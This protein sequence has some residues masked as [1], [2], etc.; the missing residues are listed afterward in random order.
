[1]I[2]FYNYF[3]FSYTAVHCIIST[4]SD[5]LPGLTPT[6][7]TDDDQPSSAGPVLPTH[8]SVTKIGTGF[9]FHSLIIIATGVHC[10]CCQHST[11][12][13]Q[14]TLFCSAE[15]SDLYTLI[16]PIYHYIVVFL[17]LK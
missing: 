12:S 16:L 6:L 13:S 15:N 14:M 10:S 5:Q 3:Y 9:V 8:L 4:V 2:Y 11:I 1:M 17:S 7:L